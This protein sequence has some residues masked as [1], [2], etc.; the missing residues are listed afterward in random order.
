MELDDQTKEEDDEAFLHPDTAHVQVEALPLRLW[1]CT[2][3]GHTT[4]NKLDDECDDVEGD[5]DNGEDGGRED[6]NFSSG[7]EEMNDAGE[8][9]SIVC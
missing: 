2:R 5:E 3:T 9:L 4:A 8:D 1:T 7:G 6:P